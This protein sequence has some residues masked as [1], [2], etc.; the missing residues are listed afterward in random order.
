M[1][2]SILHGKAK[3][4]VFSEIY[5]GKLINIYHTGMC[6]KGPESSITPHSW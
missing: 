3:V 4:C 6:I 5:D 1:D 2:R